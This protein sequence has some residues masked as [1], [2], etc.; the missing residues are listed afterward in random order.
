MEDVSQ[1]VCTSHDEISIVIVSWESG[2]D[3]VNCVASLAQ[4]RSRVLPDGPRVSLVVVDNASSEFPGDELRRAWHDVLVHVNTKN[5]GFGPAANQGARRATGD[6]VLFLNPDT[7]TEGDPF[8]PLASGFRA[9]PDAVAIAPRLIGASGWTGEPQEEFQLRRLPTLRQAARELLLLDKLL[10]NNPGR[11]RDRYADADRSVPFPIEQGAAAALAVRRDVFE[12]AGGFDETFVPAWFED[13]DL[14]ARLLQ[15]GQILFW[16]ASTFVH[17][18]G[19]A[20]RRLG[21][22]AFLP[23]YYRNAHRYWRKHHGLAAAMAFRILVAVGMLLRLAVLPIS[24]TTH[25]RQE[26]AA[27]AWGRVLR[28]AVSPD[29]HAT[30]PSA[31]VAARGAVGSAKRLVGK[32]LRILR[33]EGLRRF[34]S[35]VLAR[36]RAATGQTRAG[37]DPYTKWLAERSLTRRACRHIELD[38]AS[39]PLQPTV[40]LLMPVFN[41]PI[42]FLRAAVASVR[43]QVYP[44]WELCITDD[45][46][47]PDVAAELTALASSDSRIRLIRSN[48]NEGIASATNR[49]LSVATGALTG[50]LDHDDALDASA[51]YHVVRKLVLSPELDAAYTDRD[52][53]TADGLRIEP[54]FKPD[55]SPIGLLAHNFPIHLLVVRTTLLRRLGGLRPEFDGA[56]DYDLLLR[57]AEATDRVGHV[58]LPLYSWRRHAGSNAGQARPGAFDAGRRALEAALQRRGLAGRAE[59]TGS[60]GPYRIRLELVERPLISI[61]ISTRDPGLLDTCTRL[62]AEHTSYDHVEIVVATNAVGH[63]GLR[64]LSAARGFQLVEVENGFYSRMNNVAVR[65]ARGEMVLFLNDDTEVVTRD[66]IEEMLGWLAL[67]KVAAVGPKLVYPDGRTQFTRVVMGIRR[68]GVPYFFDPFDYSGRAWLDGF[69]LEVATEVSAVSGGCML[70][71]RSLFLDSGGFEEET[72]GFS[73]QDVDWALRLRGKG[74]R[75]VY[76]PHAMLVHRGSFSKR[77]LPDM[78]A[79]EVGLVTEFCRQHEAELRHGDPFWSPNLLD[80]NGLAVP[81]PFPGVRPFPLAAEPIA[82]SHSLAWCARFTPEADDPRDQETGLRSC[83]VLTRRLQDA[84]GAKSVV[85]L[86]CGRGLLLAAA[87]AEGLDAWGLERSQEAAS[88]AP[89]DV[90]SRIVLGDLARDSDIAGLE[91][92]GPFA[93]A[94]CTSVLDRLPERDLAPAL[95]ALSRLAPV[96]V[97]AVPKPDAWEQLDPFVLSGGARSWWADRARQAGLREDR[98]LS[99]ALFGEHWDEDPEWALF[100]LRRSPGLRRW[101]GGEK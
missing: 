9:R 48:R 4:A 100:A 93:V 14:C 58:P 31:P 43:S 82:R 87:L 51:L 97:V 96:L 62:L 78:M 12:R 53:M 26:K 86:G 39:F 57:L 75:F 85:D 37:V 101:T 68:D 84:L 54:Y 11:R 88:M 63:S 69:S 56:Q 28:D 98:S 71:P 22:D 18:G 41:P 79:R 24:P 13:V 74:W 83:R 65:A 21:Y 95:T 52:T 77:R 55:W 76:T 60:S 73:Y 80:V 45:G 72:F 20:A 92:R 50:F 1:A 25:R 36:M 64:E 29:S 16:P 66:W 38:I 47:E 35:R 49:A 42:S 89:R 23:I 17:L 46:S 6:V 15:H 61:V 8:T 7:R 81:P 3:L 67:P 94:V 99:S 5:R 2:T 34:A 70:T 10:P 91:V 44:H 90:R 40:S 33:D 19:A 59:L 30:T 27:R 32:G